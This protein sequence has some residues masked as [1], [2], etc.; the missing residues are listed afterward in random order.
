MRINFY[1]VVSIIIISLVGCKT[2]EPNKEATTVQDELQ[3]LEIDHKINVED[4]ALND[5]IY[6]PIYSDVY[7]DLQ[8]PALPLSATLSIRNTDFKDSLFINRLEYF[9]TQ[10]ELVRDYLKGE[11][12]GLPPMATINY[13]IE[14]EDDTG[15]AGANFI[16]SIHAKNNKI[17][18][19]I[20][21]VMV[22]HSGNKGFAFT[23]D[24]YSIL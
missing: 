9:N 1:I 15:G 24:G 19:I 3:A 12:I 2:P 14:K 20:Q 13:V 16:V 21:A 6:V 18:P 7:A 4:L 23:T 17:A 10:G 5:L 8:N 22:H 11:I